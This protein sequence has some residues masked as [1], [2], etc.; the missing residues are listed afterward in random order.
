MKHVFKLAGL[1]LLILSINFVYSCKKDKP[2]QPSITTSSITAISYTTAVSGGNVTDE[3][4]SPLLSMGICWSI[5]PDATIEDSKTTQNGA[6]GSFVSNLSQLSPNT[7]YYVRAYA[8][9]NVGTGYGREVSFTTSAIAAPLLTTVTITSIT[10]SSAIS[11][12]NI[13]TDNGGS[14]TVRGICWSTTSNPTISDPKTTDGSGIGSFISNL[15]GLTEGTLYHIRSYATNEAGTTYGQD[16]TFT[17]LA[18]PTLITSDL[19]GITLSSAISG[20]NISSDGGSPVIE[21]GVCW[22]I[23]HNP[24]ISDSKVINGSG[25]GTF[26]INMN[27]LTPNSTYYL[28]AY[29]T[30]AVGTSYGN[31]LNLKTFAVIDADGNG[32]YSVALGTQTWMTE[33]LRTTKFNNGDPIGTTTSDITNET[34]PIYQ[35]NYDKD[36]GLTTMYGR[37]YTWYAAIDDR[38]I[39]PTGWHL[40]TPNEFSSMEV[41]LDTHGYDFEGNTSY[42][43]KSLASTSGWREY[44]TPGTP[45]F[46]QNTNNSS[47][48]TATPGGYRIFDYTF[49]SE[50]MMSAFWTSFSKDDQDAFFQNIGNNYVNLFLSYANKK[51]GIPVRCVK[52]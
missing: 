21:R 43:A 51:N 24:T 27:G 31:E 40:P 1:F 26:P 44:S 38:K 15:I 10:G 47:G 14:V 12:G 7:K 36:P 13:T 34:T 46:D 22:S 4:T 39:C 6:V 48:F 41:Y 18:K 28:R 33:N 11:G 19:S 3:G 30:N 8:T 49:G 17:T 29:A 23:V 52:D 25:V 20:G 35:W 5:S 9:S 42:V 50:T 45:G 37:Y 16:L 32:Y 2:V